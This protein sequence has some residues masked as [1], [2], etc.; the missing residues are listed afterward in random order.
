MYIE[1]EV[2]QDQSLE[3]RCNDVSKKEAPREEDSKMEELG[4]NVQIEVNSGI[5][6]PGQSLEPLIN[7]ALRL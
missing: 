3:S 4:D 7:S 6:F 2:E 1:S 5:D